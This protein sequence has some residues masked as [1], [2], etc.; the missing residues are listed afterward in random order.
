[1]EQ[2]VA[3]ALRVTDEILRCSG[4]SLSQTQRELLTRKAD[5]LNDTDEAKLKDLYDALWRGF[6]SCAAQGWTFT[7]PS[8][9][10]ET[11]GRST[12]ENYP[13]A[14][15][16]F[17]KLATAYWTFKLSIQGL[18]PRYSDLAVSQ[19]LSQFE[20][21]FASVFFPTPGPAPAPQH[22]R[23][24]T[25]RE[26]IKQSGAP[27]DVED[28]I[29]GNPILQSQRSGDADADQSV[30]DAKGQKLEWARQLPPHLRPTQSQMQRLENIRRETKVGHEAFSLVIA[31][32][33]ATTRRVQYHLY[34]QLKREHPELTDQE[35]L[36]ALVMSRWQTSIGAGYDLFDLGQCKSDEE[37]ERRIQEVVR[38]ARTIEG[39]VTQLTKEESKYATPPDP[40]WAL[41]RAAIDQILGKDTS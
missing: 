27:I 32:H 20:L 40:K 7:T 39:L 22:L 1:M 3:D 31:G 24:Q 37:V 10:K 18:L 6:F 5:S 36:A 33:P 16:I 17:L 41:A 19:L 13:T 21:E 23:E 34:E 38:K 15:K 30:A 2:A 26:L 14:N 8:R 11:F 35:A 25:Q 9:I 4:R 12:E 28:F 29:R